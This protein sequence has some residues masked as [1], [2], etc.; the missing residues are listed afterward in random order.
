[1]KTQREGEG[2]K[3]VWKE[4][5]I[6]EIFTISTGK[7]LTQADMKKGKKPFI[8]ASDSNNG[9][10]AFVSNSNASQDKN[11]LGVN[12]N[13]SIVESFYHPYQ[14]IFSDDV[15]R[16]KIKNRAGDKYLYLFLKQEI[17]KQKEKY[18]YGYKFNETRMR[19]Q[20]IV[21]SSTE[22]EQPNYDY[23][24]NYMRKI[25]TKLLARYVKYVEII[26]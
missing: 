3:P 9:I 22:F 25:E 21:L 14:C 12:Y 24:R 15:K 10:T 16:F 18:Q 17:L 20:T 6:E 19:N 23:M 4:F 11:V 1:L 7:R 26:L 5:K 2:L 8:G 13:G